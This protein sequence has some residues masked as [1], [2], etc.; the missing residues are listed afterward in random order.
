MLIF[1]A[2][3][4]VD[5]VMSVF[6]F[7]LYILSSSSF[8]SVDSYLTVLFNYSVQVLQKENFHLKCFLIGQ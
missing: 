7:I 6:I 2:C 1:L 8:M 4:Y 5:T 3:V